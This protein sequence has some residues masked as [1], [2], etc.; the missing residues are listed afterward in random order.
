MLAASKL[1]NLATPDAKP[2]HIRAAFQIFDEQGVVTDE[3]TY[4]ESWAS[5]FQFKR[6]FTGKAFSQSAYG[7]KKGILIAGAQDAPTSCWLHETT[8]SILCPTSSHRT[9]DIYDQTA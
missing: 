3:G 8:W 1:D 2:W 4:E 7:S 6:T 5:A 9:H